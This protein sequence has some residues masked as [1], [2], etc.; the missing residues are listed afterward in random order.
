MRE[1]QAGGAGGWKEAEGRHEGISG[2]RIASQYSFTENKGFRAIALNPHVH[3][4][5]VKPLDRQ[6][7]RGEKSLACKLLAEDM[8]FLKKNVHKGKQLTRASYLARLTPHEHY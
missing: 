7:L 4:L 5:L 1:P 2:V 8:T 6:E 3:P